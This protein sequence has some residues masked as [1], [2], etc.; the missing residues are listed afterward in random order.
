MGAH[1]GIILPQ[2]MRFAINTDHIIGKTPAQGSVSEKVTNA[3]FNIHP[4]ISFGGTGLVAK[5]IKPIQF[6]TQM[7]GQ[8]FEHIAPLVKS[9]FPQSGV[10]NRSSIV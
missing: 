10:A 6:G 8:G 5:G 9:H 2:V 4:A 7:Q 1:E 3:A